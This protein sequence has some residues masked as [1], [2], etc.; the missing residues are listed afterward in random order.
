LGV[1]NGLLISPLRAFFSP[2][3]RFL[4]DRTRF[5][6]KGDSTMSTEENKALIRRFLIE[7]ENQKKLD[8]VDEVLAS[9]FILDL[10]GFPPV[11]GPTGFKQ[12]MPLFFLAFPDLHHTIKGLIAEDDKV[13]AI[14]TTRAT[15]QGEF[16]GI[17]PTG[18]QVTW[19]MVALYRV[20]DGQIVEDRVQMDLLGLMQ[21]L[22]MD[23]TPGQ[24]LPDPTL[25]VEQAYQP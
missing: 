12:V 16:M 8:V 5:S 21:Q 15:H 24:E 10:P 3:V 14:V 11:H 6:Y 1:H 19:A 25:I 17:P 13:V 22:G 23:I 7:V 9:D 2:E 20:A 18:K 4:A